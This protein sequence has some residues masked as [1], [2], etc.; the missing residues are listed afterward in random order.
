[1]GIVRKFICQDFFEK[2]VSKFLGTFSYGFNV[3]KMLQYYLY[4][5]TLAQYIDLPAGYE[6][7]YCI[8]ETVPNTPA[9]CQ[10]MKGRGTYE[11]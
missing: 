10:R 9:G 3:D 1:M 6:P 5:N 11:Q 4:L 7:I 8:S 2:K